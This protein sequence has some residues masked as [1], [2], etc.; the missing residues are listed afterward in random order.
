MEE[1]NAEEWTSIEQLLEEASAIHFVD[2]IY[3]G[4]T[5]RL[6]WKEITE[7][8]ELDLDAS[9]TPY[10]DL[11]DK[12]KMKFNAKLLQAE[13]LARIHEAGPNDACLNGNVVSKEDWYKLPEIVR[14]RIVNEVLEIS[15]SLEDR[16]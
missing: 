12:D 13:T 15:K 2:A 6:A 4:K 11:T 7:G 10:K 8:R 1:K 5:I 3:R 16:F 9:S 14:S